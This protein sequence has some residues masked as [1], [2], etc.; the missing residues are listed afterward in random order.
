VQIR[1][2][3]EYNNSHVVDSGHF[4]MAYSTRDD[5]VSKHSSLLLLLLGW[6]DH[7]VTGRSVVLINGAISGRPER[8]LLS[9]QPASQRSRLGDGLP[10]IVRL[11]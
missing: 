4:V 1:A 11:W 7:G 9:G 5:V 8:S 3:F 6:V 2:K 10:S